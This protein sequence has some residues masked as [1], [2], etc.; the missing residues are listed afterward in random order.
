MN[1]SQQKNSVSQ[2]AEACLGIICSHHDKIPRYLNQLLAKKKYYVGLYEVNQTGCNAKV[3]FTM[4]SS[5][6]V[7]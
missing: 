5:D 3:Y 1:T 6:R 2:E 4:S 7:F